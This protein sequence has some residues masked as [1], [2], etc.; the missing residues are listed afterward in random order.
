MNV[1]G[2]I[3]TLFH[4]G[5]IHKCKPPAKQNTIF[6]DIKDPDKVK[7]AIVNLQHKNTINQISNYFHLIL[8]PTLQVGKYKNRKASVDKKRGK[9]FSTLENYHRSG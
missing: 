2:I 9:L 6:K 5:D 8:C 3:P 4:Y 7:D 1:V